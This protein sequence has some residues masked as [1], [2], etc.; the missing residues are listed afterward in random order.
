MT[1]NAIYSQVGEINNSINE[2][3]I[4]NHIAPKLPMVAKMVNVV[5]ILIDFNSRYQDGPLL[6]YYGVLLYE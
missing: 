5:T 4:Q 2:N 6:S 3:Y 1:G